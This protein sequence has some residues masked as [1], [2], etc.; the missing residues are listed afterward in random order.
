MEE[1][2]GMQLFK[3][4][5]KKRFLTISLVSLLM[6][7]Y[8][9]VASLMHIEL[10]A[11]LY[12][13]YLG[14]II[15]MVIAI[16]DFISYVKKYRALL[17]SYH[18][19]VYGLEDLPKADDAIEAGYS[20]LS[21]ACYED[22]LEFKK[23][24]L[25]REEEAHDYYTLWTHQIKTPIAA[26]H[27]VLQNQK[28]HEDVMEIRRECLLLEGELF[29]VEQY[30]EMALGYLRIESLSQDLVLKEYRL[31]DIVANALKKYAVYFIG[32]K[33]SIELIPFE[34]KVVTDE[35]WL[36]FVIEQIL[37]NSIKY[38]PSGTI[39]ICMK[40]AHTLA[41]SDTGIGISEEDLPRIFDRGFT[42]YNGRMDKKSTGIGLYLCKKVMSKLSHKIEVHSVIGEGTTFYIDFQTSE[43]VRTL[44]E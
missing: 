19:R 43:A 21:L 28:Q 17:N 42:G 30:V 34:E 13:T 16:W 40:D 25:K 6:L 8:I 37:S 33:L 26:M 12:S 11:A 35:K 31:Y 23:K 7:N 41:I 3:A 20:A 29:K 38:T 32:K 24:I 39:T 15:G 10:Q 44:Q 27:L 18:G 5:L 4:W 14:V 22:L 2:K 36:Q 9:V 1:K